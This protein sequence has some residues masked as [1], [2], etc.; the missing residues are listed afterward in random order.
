M[1]LFTLVEAQAFRAAALTAYTAAIGGKEYEIKDRKLRR[2]EIEQL[3][4]TLT[5]WTKYVDDLNE[6]NDPDN[7]IEIKRIVPVGL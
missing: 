5:K 4:K 7:P 1:A 3:L 2:Q 6:G